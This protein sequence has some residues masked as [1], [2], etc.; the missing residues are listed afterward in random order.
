MVLEYILLNFVFGFE[1]DKEASIALK[2]FETFGE[3]L[4]KYY[5]FS[6]DLFQ[7]I[8]RYIKLTAFS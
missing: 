6:E 7:H 5:K 4:C 8:M 2:D 3:K 1:E